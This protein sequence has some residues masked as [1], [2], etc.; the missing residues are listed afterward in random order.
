M[1]QPG[2]R[3]S[4]V[5]GWV[6]TA[7]NTPTIA[8]VSNTGLHLGALRLDRTAPA[9]RRCWALELLFDKTIVVPMGVAVRLLYRMRKHI[10]CGAVFLG[11]G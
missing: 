4:V 11:F 1:A 9:C 6:K 8:S 7:L 3:V 2:W 5:M 10:C